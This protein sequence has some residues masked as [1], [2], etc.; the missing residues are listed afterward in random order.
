MPE[1]RR[2]RAL[3]GP[4]V[5]AEPVHERI[6]ASPA[7]VAARERAKRRQKVFAIFFTGDTPGTRR[8]KMP[9]GYRL[10]DEITDPD[11]QARIRTMLRRCQSLPTRRWSRSRE[12]LHRPALVALLLY[13]PRQGRA[14]VPNVAGG[15][16]GV[17]PASTDRRDRSRPRRLRNVADANLC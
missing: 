8:Q 13:R 4:I 7:V 14:G 15:N 12:T 9:A 2:D 5:Q 16:R 11:E 17:L 10:L 6:Q 3:S 1:P